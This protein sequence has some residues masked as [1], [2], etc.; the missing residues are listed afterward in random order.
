MLTAPAQVKH[1]LAQLAVG[2]FIHKY[3]ENIHV[4]IIANTHTQSFFFFFFFGRYVT[5][6][7]ELI[8]H[9]CLTT[10]VALFRES[11]EAYRLRNHFRSR[12]IKGCFD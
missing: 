8:S 5:A 1:C 10:F 6:E 12:T 4:P 3:R 7:G 9:C 11:R 2:P